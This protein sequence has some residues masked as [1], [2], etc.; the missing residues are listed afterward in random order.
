MIHAPSPNRVVQVAVPR[1]LHAVYDY[2]VPDD[3]PMPAVGAR[4]RVPFGRSS[5]IGICISD[6]VADPH[7][8]LKAVS[9]T[10]DSTP[11]LSEDLLALANWMADYYHHPLGEVLA[12]ILPAAARKGAEA[13]LEPPAGWR[14]RAE[15]FTNKRAHAQSELFEF[16]AAREGVTTQ[17]IVDHGYKRTILNKLAALELIERCEANDATVLEA[18][19]KAT[20]AQ[21]ACIDTIG[22]AAKSG[23]YR[24][25]LLEGVTGS[26][27]T[28]VYLRAMQDV[29]NA[30]RQVLVLVPEIAL[31]PQTLG[32]FQRRYAR[33]GVAHS[34]LTDRERLQTWLACGTAKTQVLIGTRSAI[35]TPFKDLGMIIVD[36]EHDSSYKQQDGLRYSARDLAA[37]RA[38]DLNIP[39]VFGSATPSLETLYN[40]KRGRYEH[41]QLPHR[42]TGASMPSYHLI[43]M[44]GQNQTEG[45]SLP[46]LGVIRR[47]HDRQGQV[48]VFLNRRGFSPVLLCTACGWQ[49]YCPDCDAKLTLHRSPDT[50]TCHHCGLRFNVPEHC[51]QCASRQLLPIGMGT[52]RTEALLTRTFPDTPVYRIDRDTTRTNKQLNA[53]LDKINTGEPCIMVGTQMLAKGHHFPNVTLVAILNADAGFLSGDFRAPERT[54]Q[55]IVQVAGR[56]GRAERPGEVWVQTFQP[57]NPLLLSLIDEGYDGFASKEL[58]VRERLGFAP[59]KPMA[60]LRADASAPAAA[61]DFLTA[62]KRQ[63]TGVEA[64]GPAPAPMGRL[65]R[66]HR[67]QLMIVAPNRTALHR[68]LRNLHPPKHDR[69]L[70]WSIDVD[71]YDSM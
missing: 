8:Q 18:A 49:A 68:A 47:H 40:A 69:A 39:V 30:G 2:T 36:E 1:P 60:M 48:L 41:M 45:L 43:D 58:A 7:P 33:V 15:A 17:D 10:L 63:L 53:Q 62:L 14:T 3:A 57:D 22:I 26:G 31:T 4:V 66:R 38:A 64:L 5:A 71:P 24:A 67:Y 19:P 70:R 54:A 27:K 11:I 32:R 20:A 16:I 55:L 9:A 34:H 50:L 28:E 21:T 56:A 65:A 46:L 25:H 12:A 42:A 13:V 29:V 37:K 61:L 44:R 59:Y 23:Q 52:Q 35:F 6:C 51:E